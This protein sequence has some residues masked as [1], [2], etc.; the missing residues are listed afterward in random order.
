M[1][2]SPPLKFEIKWYTSFNL[3]EMGTILQTTPPEPPET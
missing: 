1:G 2:L 3:S